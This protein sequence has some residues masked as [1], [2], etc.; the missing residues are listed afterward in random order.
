MMLLGKKYRDKEFIINT[1]N[2]TTIV[3]SLIFK[4]WYTDFE[5]TTL[6][7]TYLW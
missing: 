3:Q 5:L 6:R 4:N 1:Y 7:K 2:R